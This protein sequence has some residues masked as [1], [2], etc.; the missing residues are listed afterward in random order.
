ME[1]L[2]Q[3]LRY[4]LRNLVKSPGFTAIALITLALGIGANTAIFS[5]VNAVL[6]RALP[7]ADPDRLVVI[8]REGHSGNTPATFLDWKRDNH[9]F[10]NMGAAEAWT[11]NLTGIDK[12]E[13][14]VGLHVTSD[15]FP[16][17]GVS[18]ILGRTFTS[19]EDRLGHDHE[20]VLSYGFWQRRFGGSKDVLGRTVEFN[21]EPYTVIGVMPAGFRFAPF[22]VTRAEVWSPLPLNPSDRIVN[23]KRIFARL[24][25]GVS[26]QQ[27][28][29]EMTTIAARL[30]KEFPG[31][32]KDV[33]VT[34]LKERV[35]GDLRPALLILLGA[36]G[37][38]L[39]I[40][41]AN[42]AHMLL[43][44]ASAREREIAVRA[45][46]GASRARILQQFMTE[47]ALLALAGGI[48]GV[49]IANWGLRALL[50]WAPDSITQFGSITLDE[51]VLIFALAVSLITGIA[52]GLAPAVQ[53]SALNLIASLKEGARGTGSGRRS[54][55]IRS[56]LVASEFALA[57]VLLAGAGLMIRTFIALASIDP[58]FNPHHLLTMIVSVAGAKD[59][60]ATDRTAF[61]Q[62]SLEQI[63]ALP[64]VVS[65][66]AINH[67]PLAGDDWDLPFFI[68]G[69][70][71]P[72]RG[73]E[74]GGTFRVVLPGYFRTLNIGMLRGRDFSE[75]DNQSSPHV[76]I[77]N[78]FLA[79]RHWPGEDAIGKRISVGLEQGGTPS[80]DWLTIIGV[81]QNVVRKEWNAPTE[82][83]Y[84][85]PFLQSRGYNS[86]A[87]PFSKY[88]S[89]VVRTAGDAAF[90]TS[91]VENAIRS[92][93]K[94]ITISEVQTMDE[95]VA[96]ANAQ[97]R[98]Y[99]YL[100][101]AF[102][103]VALLLA[104]VGIYGVMSHSVSRRSHEMAVRM[105]LG[106]QQSEVMGLVLRESMLLVLIGGTAGLIGA[107]ALTPMMKS[108]LFGVRAADPATFVTVAVVLGA[109]AFLGS[110]IPA[111]R[112]TKV[113]PTVA[114]RYE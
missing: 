87:S 8:L 104:A 16:V 109:V 68:E 40:A 5:V 44:R 105:A 10:E 26:L 28:Q 77:V 84:Y 72:R 43:A 91:A 17:L 13:E 56:L 96:E 4:S 50:A 94:T 25:P 83:E 7:Y 30:E 82:E 1:T 34:P 3:D 76:V 32:N 15:V 110:Y 102:A 51:R 24:R 21:A 112:A 41:C 27:A 67:L 64:G 61:Y 78:E 108:L 59:T 95:V 111:R 81:T 36:V 58:G 60:A 9:V 49:L 46:L 74:L 19:D 57:L 90:E 39:L 92:Q 11:P 113:D 79:R 35:V 65:T 55:R 53:S 29:A 114:L 106:A 101:A 98:F 62:H 97:P 23:S 2:L 86:G 99:L 22:W 70:S 18:P 45:A 54:S 107:L 48:V 75:R 33:V 52:F 37:F 100:L 6:L 38:V 88:M 63:Q 12:P 69:R 85:L 42:I 47:S 93:D 89:F 73:E 103:G 66:S 20:V 14:V 31:T 71:L 80:Q